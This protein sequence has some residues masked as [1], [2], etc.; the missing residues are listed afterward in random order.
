[1]ILPIV[2]YGHPVLRQVCDDITHD[3][4]NLDVLIAD[5][6]ETMYNSHGMGLA[7]P[8]IN[9]SIRLFVIDTEQVY[10]NS[11]EDEKD[12]FEGEQGMKK[13][14]INAHITER[15]GHEWSCDEGCLSLPGFREEVTR[16][17]IITL[18]YCD[19]H[20]VQK[21][22]TYRGLNARVIQHEYDHID[23]KLFIDRI[24]LIKRKLLKKKLDDISAG[25]VKPGYKMLFPK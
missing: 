15:S 8:Q 11:D 23:G 10:N 7:A 3:Y 16:E 22:E 13:V 4:P 20:F 2:A 21:T 25:R 9:K 19:E 24:S 17:N 6:W 1:M 14:F 5:M 18:S 12:Q